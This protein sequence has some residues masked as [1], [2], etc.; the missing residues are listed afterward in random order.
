M[1]KLMS[2]NIQ[3]FPVEYLKYTFSNSTFPFISLGFSV[4]SFWTM[5]FSAQ[6]TSPILS[7]EAFALINIL[8]ILV[9]IIS[10]KRT[11]SLYS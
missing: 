9:I 5:V 4:I 8:S 11:W 10:A 2:S 1:E 3:F 6:N 7:E